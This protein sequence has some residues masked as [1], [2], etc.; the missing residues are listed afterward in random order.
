MSKTVSSAQAANPH[1]TT[2]FTCL[3][4]TQVKKKDDRNSKISYALQNGS[5]RV[6]PPQDWSIYPMVTPDLDW[7]PVG[8]N[9][10]RPPP[11]GPCRRASAWQLKGM[12]T[13]HEPLNCWEI[14]ECG[15]GPEGVMTAT[16]CSSVVSKWR[17]MSLSHFIRSSARRGLWF[18]IA[19]RVHLLHFTS[20]RFRRILD[21][22]P[23][24]D[25]RRTSRWTNPPNCALLHR[26]CSG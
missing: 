10:S 12:P 2:L 5:P 7:K 11:A 22:I 14:M 13:V 1:W 8:R 3:Q 18:T 17:E 16:V 19:L 15:R 4:S 24:G 9:R 26:R 20:R 21:A 23:G 25:S 6:N